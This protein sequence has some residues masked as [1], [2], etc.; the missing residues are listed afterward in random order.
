M[1][2]IDLNENNYN[3][4]QLLNLFSLDDDFNINDLKLQKEKFLNYIRINAI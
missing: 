4:Q 1:E 3:Y 2:D